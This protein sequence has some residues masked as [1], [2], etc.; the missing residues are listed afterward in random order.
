MIDH[1]RPLSD[2]ARPHA[3][4][5]LQVQLIV[6]LYWNAARRWPQH[7]FRDCVCVPEVVLVTL[8]ERLGLGRRY[9]SHLMTE[10]EQ[11]AGT[12]V[13]RQTRFDPDQ[14]RRCIR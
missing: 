4:Q 13:R 14:A 1:G 8:T 2:Q 10:R 9:L 12:I 5:R 7:C 3:V 6:S 11:L